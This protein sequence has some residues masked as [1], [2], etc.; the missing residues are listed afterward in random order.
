MTPDIINTHSQSKEG[1][2]PDKSLRIL[3][4]TDSHL[5]TDPEWRLA[6]INTQ[7]SFEWV[8]DLV[9]REANTIDLLLL[10][11]DLVHD[12][13]ITGYTRLKQHIQRTGIRA[14]CLPGN[15]DRPETLHKHLTGE[16]VEV[17]K[18]V[19]LGAWV[20]VLLDSTT[21][22]SEGGHLSDQ[23]LNLLRESIN[24][25]TD[26][27]ILIALHHHPI[28]INSAWMDKISLDNPAPFLAILEQHKN[29]KG[30]VWGH[31][32]QTFEA[33]HNG[34]RMMGTPSTCIQF[35][36][37]QDQFG[38][39]TAPPGYRWLELSPDGQINSGIERAE[40]LPPGLDLKTADY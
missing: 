24:K 17:P 19:D 1:A 2:Q 28:K 26:R 3:Q 6:G 22:H 11:G 25:Y 5:H 34:I 15:H 16:R 4:I 37:N 29:V 32:H 10:T 20:L 8:M 38:I 14:S 31:I 40:A 23:E 21:P 7:T 27:Y 18:I 13:S 33:V 30:V 35:V 12:G 39:S 9:Q 36:E